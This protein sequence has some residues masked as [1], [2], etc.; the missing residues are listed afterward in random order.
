MSHFFQIQE[1]ILRYYSSILPL[2]RNLLTHLDG[3]FVTSLAV[4]VS[5]QVQKDS[6]CFIVCI[7]IWKQI[8]WPT[9]MDSLPEIN[10]F[11]CMII[12]LHELQN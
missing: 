8:L 7:S 6:I 12:E 10:I 4:G 9:L 3:L 11:F 2:K 1:H 5:G